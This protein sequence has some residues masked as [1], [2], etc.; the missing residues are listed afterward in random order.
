MPWAGKSAKQRQT[1]LCSALVLSVFQFT[2][3]CV[4]MMMMIERTASIR[5][6]FGNGGSVV[7]QSAPDNH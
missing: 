4:I 5:G 1:R 3:V 7:T 2:M 6:V